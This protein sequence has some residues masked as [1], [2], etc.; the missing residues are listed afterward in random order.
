MTQE[1]PE[2]PPDAKLM[3]LADAMADA[4]LLLWRS[5]GSYDAEARYIRARDDLRDALTQAV[6]D[7]QRWLALVKWT[8]ENNGPD[9]E[10]FIF[11][12]QPHGHNGS[13][14]GWV[15]FG[16]PGEAWKAPT[17]EQMD[18]AIDAAMRQGAQHE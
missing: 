4:N 7:A 11:S 18:A 17:K 9:T 12:W 14:Y 15:E 2:L 1:V 16:W 8:T 13:K 10:G 3:K 5:N 6:A